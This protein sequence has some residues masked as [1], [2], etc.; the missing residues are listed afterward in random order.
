MRL[1]NPRGLGARRATQKGTPRSHEPVCVGGAASGRGF[2]SRF[3]PDY[4][5]ARWTTGLV[6]GVEDG[7]RGLA[8]R[9]ASVVW[10]H[11]AACGAAHGSK[12]H[13]LT[14]C[15]MSTPP[16]KPL[17]LVLVL[18]ATANNKVLL[19]TAPYCCLLLLLTLTT[20]RPR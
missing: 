20:I 10:P 8:G 15:A 2:D 11:H 1:T 18:A 12:Q 17:P 5:R 9:L 7:A 6:H 14:P 3:A 19:L 13:P 4:I 16:T